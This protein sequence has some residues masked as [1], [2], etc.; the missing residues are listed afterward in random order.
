MLKALEELDRAL[1][2]ARVQSGRKATEDQPDGDHQARASGQ[3]QDPPEP[4]TNIHQR[5][6]AALSCETV[7]LA[8]FVTRAEL[9]L[10][11]SVDD[12]G[13]QTRLAD[14]LCHLRHWADVRTES[15][16]RPR[17]A[18]R[19]AITTSRGT[20]LTTSGPPSSPPNDPRRPLHL[21]NRLGG[22]RSAQDASNACRNRR[23]GRTARNFQAASTSLA[24]RGPNF[25]DP[26]VFGVVERGL[27]G[28]AENAAS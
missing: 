2:A 3:D 19:S 22:A 4:L 10:Y 12:D 23:S 20:T 7:S 18:R 6:L 14:L 5:V 26:P 25:P 21:G 11:V 15:I 9:A 27:R 28:I 8:S 16:S 13:P 1:C 24:G 17:L